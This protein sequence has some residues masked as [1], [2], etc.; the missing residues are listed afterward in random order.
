MKSS[1]IS[2]RAPFS[3]A[4]RSILLVAALLIAGSWAQAQR[5]T[6]RFNKEVG[7]KVLV[8]LV[9]P[10]PATATGVEEEIVLGSQR[11]YTLTGGDVVI[12][13]A[14]TGVTITRQGVREAVFESSEL[15][16]IRLASN[17]IESISLVGCTKL[18]NLQVNGNALTSLDLTQ[19]PALKILNC[20]MGTL[21]SIKVGAANTLLRSIICHTNRI[22]IAEMDDFLDKLPSNPSGPILRIVNTKDSNEQNAAS[23]AAIQRI[24][25][26]GWNPQDIFG[27]SRTS[28][29]IEYLGVD[30]PEPVTGFTLTLANADAIADKGTVRFVNAATNAEITNLQNIP[31]GTVVRIIPTP[32][33]YHT[34]RGIF[35]EMGPI[36]SNEITITGNTSIWVHFNAKSY[37]LQLVQPTVGGT[38]E[39]KEVLDG[40]VE[41][42]IGAQVYYGSQLVINAKAAAGYTVRDYLVDGQSILTPGESP[43]PT[44]KRFTYRANQTVT[45]VFSKLSYKVTAGTTPNGRV[46]FTGVDENGYAPAGTTI[47]VTVEPAPGYELISLTA[48]NLNIMHTRRFVLT[49]DVTVTA[50][51]QKI[52]IPLIIARG[53]NGSG[54]HQVSGVENVLSVPV[55][56]T[57]RLS[58]TPDRGSCLKAINVNNVNVLPI[59]PNEEITDTR[60]VEITVD[61]LMRVE[62]V[63]DRILYRLT[64]PTTIENGRLTVSGL[65]A[66]EGSYLGDIITITAT[67]DAGYKLS[68]LTA[69]GR[70]ILPSGRFSLSGHTTIEVE[71]IKDTALRAIEATQIRVFPNPASG[72]IA[73]QG[74][75]AGVRVAL[76]SQS[77]ITLRSTTATGEAFTLGLD[78]VAPGTYFLVVGE[79]VTKIQVQ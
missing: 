35:S 50:V 51:F 9:G 59:Q 4:V 5:I 11:S 38:F 20:S 17:Q 10:G 19:C 74:A 75:E 76:I 22:G 1:T 41:Q 28:E 26:R 8:H 65:Q 67:P 29:Y 30:A 34:L 62:I 58:A 54:S 39:V 60:E 66:A 12:E 46:S 37:P 64:L 70:N 14:V 44:S 52:H 68:K 77:G 3:T 79:A 73:V 55:G 24:K 43:V 78:G 2:R 7:D 32:N 63:F 48:G 40:G 69:N 15:L 25:A 27:K 45:V 71:F 18:N 42:T 36:S 21:Q 56:T 33:E 6:L 49:R 13:G 72:A 23:K 57:I 61:R 16:D 31:A 47:N 53:G